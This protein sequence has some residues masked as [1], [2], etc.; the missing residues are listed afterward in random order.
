MMMQRGLSNDVRM[1][2]IVALAATSLRCADSGPV[3]PPPPAANTAE[4]PLSTAMTLIDDYQF[5]PGQAVNADIV[6]VD[7]APGSTLAGCSEDCHLDVVV[8]MRR[9]LGLRFRL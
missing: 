1:W 5:P 2:V 3:A 4:P 8:K 6:S 7:P 9:F